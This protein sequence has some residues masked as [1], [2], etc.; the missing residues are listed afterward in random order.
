MI[1]DGDFGRCAMKS[2]GDFG[3]CAVN[4]DVAVN[5][6]DDIGRSAVN[7]DGH[8]CSLSYHYFSTRPNIAYFG[9]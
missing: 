3:R 2:D 6:D 9:G 1:S 4:S 7:S 5:S 8:L